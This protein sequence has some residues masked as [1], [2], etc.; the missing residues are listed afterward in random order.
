MH[1]FVKGF[2]DTVAACMC[3][4]MSFIYYAGEYTEGAFLK[5]YWWLILSCV[6][7]L[8]SSCY[9]RTREEGDDE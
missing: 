3:L 7:V 5:Q 8:S 4:V 9:L 6:L 1:S 2:S